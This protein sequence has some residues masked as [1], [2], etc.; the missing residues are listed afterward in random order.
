MNYFHRRGAKLYGEETAIA[1]IAAKVGTPFY[2]Y[3]EATLRRHF[4]AFDRAFYALPHLT[5]FSVKGCSNIGL[6]ALFNVLGSGAD[7]VSGGELYRAREAGFAGQKIVYSGVGKSRAEIE[8]ALQSDI[9]MFNV[10]SAPEL[11][12]LNQIAGE[13]GRK[14]PVGVRVNPDVDP[15]THPY[16][17]TG[18]KQN[19]FGLD[20][21]RAMAAYRRAHELPHLEV[22]GLDFH[23]GSQ[24]TQT[25]PFIETIRKI[26]ELR[27]R[28]ADAGIHIEYLDLG[29]GLGITYRDEQPPTP[30]EYAQAIIDELK[31]EDVFLLLE[32]G[33]VITGN[34]GLLITKVL[35]VKETATKNF[36]VVDAAMNDLIRPSLYSAYHRIEPVD[37]PADETIIADVV[38]PICESTD[39]LA[40]DRA[41]AR[42]AAGDLLAV[43]SAGA[44]GFVMSSN[45]NSRPR[46]AEVLVRGDKFEIIRERETYR[47]LIRGEQIPKY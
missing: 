18:L 21:E 17:S 23:I 35:Y 12:L 29:G 43:F 8:F 47:D 13:M 28:L 19:K 6:L 46:A 24:L 27:G 42:V 7:I 36:I 9:L 15:Q 2:L 4:E 5:C 26:K 22:K 33:R 30:Q 10:E 39:F 34:A 44:Y 11:E 25:A 14:A 16:I 37:A 20:T 1:N 3:S 41:I 32:P 31:D 38:G 40:K 45:Y